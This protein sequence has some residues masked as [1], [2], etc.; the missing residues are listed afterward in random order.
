YRVANGS[1]CSGASYTTVTSTTS[2]DITVAFT[3][4]SGDGLKTVCV[5]YRDAALNQS[6]T[7]TDTI[8]LDTQAPTVALTKVNGNA[9]TFPFSTNQN[10][11]SVGGT[12]GTASGDSST[13]NVTLG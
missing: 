13:I 2:L 3:L 12:C 8:T 1:D 4:T 7:A 9:V 5:Q 6:T 11:T 10:V